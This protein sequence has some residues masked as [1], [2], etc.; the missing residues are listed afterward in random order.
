MAR[1]RLNFRLGAASRRVELHS[2]RRVAQSTT[3]AVSVVREFFEPN[4]PRV[5]RPQVL[6]NE[7][8]DASTVHVRSGKQSLRLR[9]ILGVT[10]AVTARGAGVEKSRAPG[11]ESFLLETRKYRNQNVKT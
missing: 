6:H 3:T 8:L 2:A 11:R 4:Q 10:C 9:S 7:L 1:S 5:R